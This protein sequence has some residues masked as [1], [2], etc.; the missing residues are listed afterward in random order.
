[1]TAAKATLRRRRPR[2]AGDVPRELADWF[3]GVPR[4][5]DATRTPWDALVYP[6]YVVLGERW[7]AWKAEN[8]NAAPPAG[9]E[10]LDDPASP[11][12]PPEWMLGP[13]RDL[14]AKRSTRRR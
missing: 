5:P 2:G 11:R 14:I 6:D 1:M 7:Q 3:A 12:H 8:P 10:W 13:A 9:W 4:D